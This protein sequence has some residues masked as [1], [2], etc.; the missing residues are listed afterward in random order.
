VQETKNELR[1]VSGQPE[2]NTAEPC[3]EH[4]DPD[5]VHHTPSVG[6]DLSFGS[7]IN[8]HPRDTADPRMVVSLHLS[9]DAVA[10][11]MVYREV[12]PQ[13]VA[14][15]GQQLLGLAGAPAPAEMDR[16]LDVISRWVDDAPANAARDP[17]ART[18]GRLSKVAEEAG[19]VISAFIGVT[20]QNPRKGVSDHMDH[21][22]EELLDVALTALAAYVHVRPGESPMRAFEAHLDARMKRVNLT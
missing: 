16:K 19:E 13:Q 2:A 15:F 14:T 12:Q 17:E 6:W 22:A 4:C 3:D 1:P 8:F 7:R 5:C 20:G 18:W 10:T 9:D 11:G 21:V